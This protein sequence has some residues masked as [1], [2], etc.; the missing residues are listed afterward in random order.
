MG[1][2]FMPSRGR[3]RLEIISPLLDY[4]TDAYAQKVVDHAVVGTT[5]Y[6]LVSRTPKA[7]WE[8]S[9]TYV[10]DVDGSFRWIAVFLTR[11]ARD[12]YDF[13]YKDLEVPGGFRTVAFYVKSLFSKQ[14][15]F[16]LKGGLGCC[17]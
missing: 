5:V 17:K 11:K 16:L 1:W 10:N 9:T 13:G 8:P 2:T 3:D 15:D 7:A 6:L 12:G 14:Q 4:E